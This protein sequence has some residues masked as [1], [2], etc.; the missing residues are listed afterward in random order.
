MVDQWAVPAVSSFQLIRRELHRFRDFPALLAFMV[1]LYLA[2]IERYVIFHSLLESALIAVTFSTFAFTWNA[3]RFESGYLATIG[4]ACLPVGI[5]EVAHMLAYQGMAVFEGDGSNLA[6]QLWLAG[7]F[8]LVTSIL[9]ATLQGNRPTRPAWVLAGLSVLAGG[10]LLSI[11]TGHFPRAF[12]MGEGLTPF[13]VI[14]EYVIA[15]ALVA[16]FVALMIRRKE[17]PR[18]TRF[19]L[20]AYYLCGAATSLAFSSY[21]M[22]YDWSNMLGHYILLIGT[23][24]FYKA[25]VETGISRPFD[26]LFRE[27]TEAVRTRDEFLSIASHELK[28]PLTPIKLQLQGIQR[29]MRSDRLATLPPAQLAKMTDTANRQIDRLTHLVDNLL[30]VSRISAGKLQLRKETVDVNGLFREILDRHA[31]EVKSSGAEVSMNVPV[32]PVTLEADPLRID[33]VITNLF[34]NALRYAPGSR[35]ELGARREAN[36]NCLLWVEDNG[37]GIPASHQATIFD[38]FERLPA[39]A[40]SSGL[41]LGLFISRQIVEAHGGF[42]SL[43]SQMEK[44]SRFEIRLPLA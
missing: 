28:T 4:V 7:R 9:L 15:T 44:G 38:R 6:P 24:A 21:F 25:I 20:G 36:G 23:Y 43:S 41:G 5:C 34:T 22:M 37:P 19:L 13:K 30:D 12:V 40:P 32:M 1:G 26:L 16:A 29:L 18:S 11:F 27:L 35:I 42:L 14:C 39:S 2:A 8:T 31:A 17:L 10:L 33:Q 3:R